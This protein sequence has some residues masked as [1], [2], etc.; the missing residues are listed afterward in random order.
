MKT[1]KDIMTA[2]VLTFTPEMDVVSA[3]KILIERK[4][5]G[6]P[7]V[8]NPVDKTLAGILTQ[9]DLVAQQKTP[10]LPSLFTILDGFIPL[11]SPDKMEAELRKIS[12]MTVGEAM[13]EKVVTV[14]PDESLDKIASIMVDRKLHTLPVVD[15]EGALLGVIGKEDVI[16]VLLEQWKS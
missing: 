12:A 3:A 6:A 2:D 15:G 1:A 5:N 13:T 7:V 14:G 9:S 16:K 10:S 4:I 8:R 11:S